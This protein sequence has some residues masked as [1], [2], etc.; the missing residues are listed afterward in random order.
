MAAGR[1]AEGAMVPG[2]QSVPCT[3]LSRELQGARYQD[4]VENFSPMGCAG[5]GRL[6][7][8]LGRPHLNRGFQEEG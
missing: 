4:E 1:P 8:A 7:Q 5:M 6:L 2:N 3:P